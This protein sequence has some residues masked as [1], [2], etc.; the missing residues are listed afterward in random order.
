VSG[1]GEERAIHPQRRSPPWPLSS[2]KRV[3]NAE[4]RGPDREERARKRERERERSLRIPSF[5]A[6]DIL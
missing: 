2:W 6:T 5:S 3:S 1:D 4:K